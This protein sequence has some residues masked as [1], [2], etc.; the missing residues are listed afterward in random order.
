MFKRIADAGVAQRPFSVLSPIT[1]V[2]ALSADIDALMRFRGALA[3]LVHSHLK[4]RYQ[5][6]ALGFCWTLLN[7]LMMLSVLAVVFSTLLNRP[8]RSFTVYLFAGMLPWGFFSSLVL[9]GAQSL[10]RNE[11]LVRRIY[12]PKL[13]FPMV[14]LV[15][16][17]V[18]MV[19][20][21][22]ALFLL[23]LAIRISVNVQLVLLPAAFVLLAAFAL[24]VT[25]VLMVLNTFFRDIEHMLQVV[26]RV[27]Y[28]ASPILYEPE[29]IIAKSRIGAV[30]LRFNPLTYILD[31][32]HCAFC[33]EGPDW[34]R[35]P[36][37]STWLVASAFSF[38]FL[39][40]GYGAY[41]LYE[42]KLAF[43]L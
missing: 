23:L 39:L 35:W 28:F 6:S 36:A 9:G 32:F 37:A 33:S 20:A 41:K 30:L 29:R 15:E 7:P 42:E 40:L 19:F 11:T 1:W 22:A 25:L 5:R 31:I 14:V 21:M 12:V 4:I 27:W 2:R 24:G 43:R 3:Y 13:L 10:I 18:N 34:P 16:S 26:L 38:G 8:L 17:A